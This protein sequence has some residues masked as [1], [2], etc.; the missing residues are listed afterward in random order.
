MYAIYQDGLENAR[1]NNL[2]IDMADHWLRWLLMYEPGSNP[3]VELENKSTDIK[4]V[5]VFDFTYM[6]DWAR[7]QC[8]KRE[9]LEDKPT[10]KFSRWYGQ[11]LE[12]INNIPEVREYSKIPDFIEELI[13]Y[14]C[15][16]GNS[17]KLTYFPIGVGYSATNNNLVFG[18][19]F[20]AIHLVDGSLNCWG[21]KHDIKF[22]F[23]GK[24]QYFQDGGV[25]KFHQGFPDGITVAPANRY[26]ITLRKI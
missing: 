6:L 15:P 14:F 7:E 25:Y 10:R 2:T 13:E 17:M 9:F 1:F 18:K 23:D 16:H 8:L 12:S 26:L 3:R 5:G 11:G 19:K 22:L 4:C 21:V 24:S 20:T